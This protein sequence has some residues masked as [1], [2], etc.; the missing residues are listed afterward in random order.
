MKKLGQNLYLCF[1]KTVLAEFLDHTARWLDAFALMKS[2]E[3][4]KM[5]PALKT[6]AGNARKVADPVNRLLLLFKLRK[7]KMH[8]REIAET[9]GELGGGTSRM[10][11]FENYIDVLMHMKAIQ[12]DFANTHQ[13]S[14]TWDPSTYGGK[15]ILVAIAYRVDQDKAAYLLSQQLGQTVMSELDMDLVGLAKRG[16]LPGLKAS[17]R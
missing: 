17:K 15:D 12:K 14:V 3:A 5:L 8:R 13:L 11:V 7:K 2:Q 1:G 16:S 6:K 9:H 10:V 4:L